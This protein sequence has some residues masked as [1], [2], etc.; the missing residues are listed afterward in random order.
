M[1]TLEDAMH[2]LELEEDRLEAAKLSI[3]VTPLPPTASSEGMPHRTE[4]YKTDFLSL[5]GPLQA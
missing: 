5:M 3:D 1:K 2:H 4:N